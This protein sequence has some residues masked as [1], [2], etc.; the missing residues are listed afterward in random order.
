MPSREPKPGHGRVSF[1][2]QFWAQD[3]TRSTPH[4]RTA[5]TAWRSAV[6][7]DGVPL[8]QLRRCD[9]DARDTTRLPGC[10]KVYIRRLSANGAPLCSSRATT[11]PDT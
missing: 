7:H 4:A 5:A 2:A 6:E 8:T 9:P 11:E 1:D 10:A 3:L